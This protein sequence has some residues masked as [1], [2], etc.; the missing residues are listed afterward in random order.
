MKN[1]VWLII[2]ITIYVAILF[3]CFFPFFPSHNSFG[4]IL[5]SGIAIAATIVLAVTIGY[6]MI[7]ILEKKDIYNTFVAI[8]LPCMPIIALGLVFEMTLTTLGY[9][10]LMLFPFWLI[11]S[12]FGGVLA[13]KRRI[14]RHA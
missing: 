2:G 12:S 8:L 9:A 1:S 10:F 13:H 4:S 3:I 14:K 5:L 7:Y 6:L 11:A